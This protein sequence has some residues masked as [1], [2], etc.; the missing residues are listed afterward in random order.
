MP[1]LLKERKSL[2]YY[3]KLKY[4]VTIHEA[5]EGGYF[6]E[7]IDLPGCMAQAETLDDMHKEIDI[8]RKLWLESMYEDG[9]EI[10]LPR[11]E[12]E[13]SGKFIIRVPK[14]LHYKLNQIAEREGVS[15]NQY[16]V[17]ALSMAVGHDEAVKKK[18][19]QGKA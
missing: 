3:L 18:T 14:S 10:P 9:K 19:R 2:E 11:N 6:A 16:L 4:P 15:L 8:A 1:N 5:K 12:N 13:Y 17:S 7:I